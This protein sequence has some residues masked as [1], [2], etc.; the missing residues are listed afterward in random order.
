MA[1]IE[2]GLPNEPELKVEDVP[3][4]TVVE[5]IKEEPK[6]IEVTETADGGAEVSF[7]PNA[8]DPISDSHLQNLAELLDDSILDPLGSDKKTKNNNRVE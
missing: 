2:K 3:V 6:E 8:V 5:E 7:D 4:K 1:E